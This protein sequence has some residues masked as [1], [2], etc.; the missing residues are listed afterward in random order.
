MT[1]LR[2]FA[3]FAATAV[4]VAAC[5]SGDVLSPP[6]DNTDGP[7]IQIHSEGG[8]VPVEWN[9]GRGPTFTVTRDGEFIFQGVTTLEYPGRLVP[10][11]MVAQLDQAELDEI[12]RL[13]EEM[14]IAAIEDEH[15]DSVQNVADATTEVIRYWDESGVH[16]YS[17]YALGIT[18]QATPEAT[19][20]FAELFDY[21]HQLSAS[22][23]AVPY[24][25]ERVRIVA[26]A[27]YEGQDPNFIDIR[28]WPLEGENPDNWDLYTTVG[29]DQQWT[30]KV[31]DASVLEDFEDATQVTLWT[32]PSES[33]D[34]QNFK[35]LVRPLHPGEEDCSI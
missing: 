29:E 33:A 1:R 8:F 34:A 35:L 28:D 25:P 7:L 9:L 26:G 31:F 15:D 19:A 23:D 32:H 4:V 12:E 14:G 20:V 17:V 30:C 10:P 13:L 3:A 16:R 21:L 24:E 27:S 22:V 18:D 6:D 2:I 5:G 11:Y